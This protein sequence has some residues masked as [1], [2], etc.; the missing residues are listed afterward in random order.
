MTLW[1]LLWI[2]L[3]AAPPAAAEEQCLKQVFGRY[4]LGGDLERA[5]RG[6]PAPLGRQSNGDSLALVFADDADKLYLLAYKGQIYKVVRAYAISTQ[7]RFDD[8]YNDLRH[9]YGEGEDDS[10]FPSYAN[11]P[12]ARL[13]SIR[14]GE[15]RAVH[16]WKPSPEWHI[17]L[18]WTRELG[19]SLAYIATALDAE[20]TAQTEGGL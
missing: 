7:L 16:R 17:E 10:R 9:I 18:S 11:A 19:V 13:A 4:C 12:A 8:I 6:Q 3:S 1:A 15:G 2:T 20:R 14:R 5:V